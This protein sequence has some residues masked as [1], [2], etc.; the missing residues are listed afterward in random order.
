MAQR[1]QGVGGGSA[2]RN[3]PF[4]SSIAC[5]LGVQ[6]AT[7]V[8]PYEI[9]VYALTREGASLLG[10][11]TYVPAAQ[12]APYARWILAAWH[13]AAVGYDVQVNGQQGVEADWTTA[14]GLPLA[15]VGVQIIEDP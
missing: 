12:P 10:I 1:F 9:R 7:D 8:G 4:G 15:C 2:L 3:V 14:V 6:S 13:P 11:V 5:A